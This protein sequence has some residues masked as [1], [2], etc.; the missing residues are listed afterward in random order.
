M[1]AGSS[2]P[3][4]G[5]A[6]VDDTARGTLLALQD[7]TRRKQ[8]LAKV[9]ADFQAALEHQRAGRLD[10]AELLYKKVLRKAPN[11]PDA[12]HLLGLIALSQGRAE[13]AVELIQ[14]AIRNYA[15][16]IGDAHMN[17][18]N[19]YLAA[20]R[21]SEA[22]ASY[23]RAIAIDPALAAAHCNLG[24]MLIDRGEFSA[25][26]STCQ[27]AASLDPHLVEG[28]ANLAGA[29]KGLGRLAEAEAALR[30]AL[31]LQPGR[32]DLLI[33]LALVLGEL[34]RFD[35]A[36]TAH[37]LATRAQPDAAAAH[38]AYATTLTRMHEADRA[39]E[40]AGR[41]VAL[42]PGSASCWL[43]LGLAERTLGR[44]EEAERCIARA[45]AIDP[46]MTEAR[47][48]LAFT[49][50]RHADTDEA[51]RL[52]ATL[53]VPST[54]A[55]ERIV[56]GFALGKIM[57]DTD[58]FDEAFA[59]FA[60]ANR[61][62]RESRAEAGERFDA[63][64]F[65][66][67]IDRLIA[68]SPADTFGGFSAWGNTSDLP[69]FIVGMPRSGTT[70]VEQIAASHSQVFGAGEI[71]DINAISAQ[72]TARNQG[73]AR[74]QDWD[75]A[76][77]RSLADQHVDRLRRLGGEA[78]RVINKTPDNLMLLGLVAM[79]FPASRVVFVRRDP[80]DT[81]LSNFF[82]RFDQGNLFA[83]DLVDCG[84]RTRACA[85]LAEHWQR[86]LP[87]R[88]LTVDYEALV[89][90]L[91]GQSR[92]LIDFLGLDWEPACLDFHRTQR[93]VTT[94]SVWQVRQQIYTRS[95]G[96]WRHYER[97]LGPLMCALQDSD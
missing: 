93:A 75:A 78:R 88:M 20:G 64:E 50:R 29:L 44:I 36:V 67:L 21:R 31:T 77:A 60:G 3:R 24:K 43:A 39:R 5:S 38:S 73:M 25:A 4:F 47:W 35:E 91:Q 85:R 69:V 40:H 46:Q 34:E 28:H 41:A 37:E 56:A 8:P 79:L 48:H 53:A 76:H 54:P 83:Y 87:L 15:R 42:A 1:T 66:H 95:V 86:V 59:C 94:L 51:E 65:E 62:F 92:R 33:G 55:A 2:G 22:E 89:G 11:M 13:R 97:H 82:Q 57:D 32:A 19:A 71:S 18:G 74:L 68:Q 14:K 12:L 9:V 63:A 10:R 58:R 80:R 52:A 90:D 7:D 61:L 96:R 84:I 16:N 81:A 30:Q 27:L 70:L 17:L 26:L 45:V 72:V 23:R 49:G 6:P